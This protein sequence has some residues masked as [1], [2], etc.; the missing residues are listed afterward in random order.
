M[1]DKLIHF[2]KKITLGISMFFI[3]S[4]PTHA[5]VASDMGAFFDNMGFMTNTTDRTSYNNQRASYYTGGRIFARTPV[6]NINL[7]NL[8]LP[9][10]R[11]GCGGI[12]L[13]GGAFSFIDSDQ[14][15]SAIKNIGSNAVGYAFQLGLKTLTPH[16]ASALETLQA[17]AQKINS[18]NMS[19]CQAAK[20]VVDSAADMM[21]LNIRE[22]CKDMGTSYNLFEDYAEAK[23]KCEAEGQSAAVNQ[24]AQQDP[25][26]RESVWLDY[27]LA[28]RILA[29]I[30]EYASPVNGSHDLAFLMMSLT[31]TMTSTSDGEKVTPKSHDSIISERSWPTLYAGG[32]IEV[33]AC[34]AAAGNYNPAITLDAEGQLC[35]EM[36]RRVI[37]IQ[38]DQSFSFRVD[39]HLQNIMNA[40]Q[41]DT[42]LLD[43]EIRFLN[44]VTI[45]VYKMIQVAMAYDMTHAQLMAEQ[46]NEIIALDLI[47]G[48][49]TTMLDKFKSGA[50]HVNLKPTDYQSFMKRVDDKRQEIASIHKRLLKDKETSFELVNEIKHLEKELVTELPREIATKIG[51]N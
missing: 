48:Y 30:E 24:Q 9:T 7:T 49:L 18:L 36:E 13:F 21:N 2:L 11:A 10:I 29:K 43:P 35:T 5:D 19:S 12:D 17:W 45:P 38:P 26:Y 25:V 8:Q 1:K 22:D 16:I 3:A 47:R 31:G 4:M 15:V 51:M 32:D 37:T 50:Q 34:V 33:Y 39:Q 28:I 44:T 23:Q 46:Y 6:R 40:I 42:E 41:T 20:L 27:N 14:L